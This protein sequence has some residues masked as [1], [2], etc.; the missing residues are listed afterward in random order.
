MDASANVEGDRAQMWQLNQQNFSAGTFGNPQ[1]LTT[2]IKYWQA[3]EQAHYPGARAQVEYFQGK[4]QEQLAM[5]EQMA[6]AQAAM[7]Q[8]GQMPQGAPTQINNAVA[9]GAAIGG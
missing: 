9:P 5:R 3:Q 2:T 8:M 6:Q 4:Y 7:P 1:E